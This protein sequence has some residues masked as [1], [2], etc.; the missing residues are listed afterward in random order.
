MGRKRQPWETYEKDAFIMRLNRAGYIVDSRC[1]E[2]VGMEILYATEENDERAK[3]GTDNERMEAEM[4]H[5]VKMSIHNTRYPR[6]E[7]EP[8]GVNTSGLT[9]EQKQDIDYLLKEDHGLGWIAKEVGTSVTKVSSYIARKRLDRK[10][11]DYARSQESQ[12][13]EPAEDAGD[14]DASC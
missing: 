11:A 5:R 8:D 1:E 4:S 7:P 6:I 12:A 3:C 13:E 9:D 2:T 14:G 10:A